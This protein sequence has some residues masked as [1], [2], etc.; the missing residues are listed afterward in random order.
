MSNAS[1]LN[2]VRLSYDTGKLGAIDLVGWAQGKKGSGVIL[3]SI[4]STVY[5]KQ[6]EKNLFTLGFLFHLPPTPF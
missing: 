5:E 2:H 1:I 3:V 4:F 6:K